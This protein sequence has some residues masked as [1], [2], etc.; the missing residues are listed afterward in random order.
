MEQQAVINVDDIRTWKL[1]IAANLEVL[2]R[3]FPG[4]EGELQVKNQ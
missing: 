1:A 2:F 3:K 4:E